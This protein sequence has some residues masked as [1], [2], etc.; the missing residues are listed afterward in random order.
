M[1][2][3]SISAGIIALIQATNEVVSLCY[4]PRLKVRLEQYHNLAR[5][6]TLRTQLLARNEEPS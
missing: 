1:D 4:N 6:M 5:A 3:L 2:P